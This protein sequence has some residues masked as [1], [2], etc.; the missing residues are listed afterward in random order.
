M[1]RP[2]E[3]A[4]LAGEIRATIRLAAPL[5][6]TQLATVG[7]NVLEIMLAG[8]ID[9]R[10]MGAVAIGANVWQFV[11]MGVIGVMM[12]VSP[13][14]A[15][16]DGAGRRREAAHEFRQALWLGLA[17]G[18]IA[19]IVLE[20]LG[21]VLVATIGI[22]PAL[23]AEA[24]RFVRWAALGAPTLGPYV[25]CR[26]LTEGLSMPRPS[27]AF[28]LLGLAILAPLGW[29]LMYPLGLGAAGLGA[30]L[31]ITIW[32]QLAA[33]LAYIRLAPRY[34]GLD[35]SGSLRPDRAA[36]LALFRLGGPMAVSIL[37]EAGMFS[38]TALLIG[39]FGDVAVSGHQIALSVASVSFMVPLG[40]AIATTVRVGN[41][42]GRRDPAGVR[43]A[44]AIGLA[45][46]L[47]SQAVAAGLMLGI[48][49]PIAGLYTEDTAVIAFAAHLLF[50]AALF[51]LSDGAQVTAA[52]ALRGLKDARVPMLLTAA[53]Y[54]LIGM[55]LGWTLTFPLEWQAPGMWTG[56]ILALS[57]AALLLW[58]R[59]V[60]LSARI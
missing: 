18:A 30:A 4:D 55:P 15:Q 29:V 57:A 5:V 17:V 31:A 60:R 28:G 35:W 14:V 13:T 7:A 44:A 43:R 37:M 16:L 8:H 51:Q 56:L 25:V 23:A 2:P 32:L 48:P 22:A 52:A 58:G 6:L 33:F 45:L 21:P 27:L 24:D 26:G 39:R 36:I 11:S 20:A 38:A 1:L 40:L 46:A 54:W 49:R 47:V 42:A 9:P 41:A 10:V 59:F 34:A 19:L 12:A 53:A 50:F 3:P